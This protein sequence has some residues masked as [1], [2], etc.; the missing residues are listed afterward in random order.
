MNIQVLKIIVNEK[1]IRKAE[2]AR[3]SNVSR[4][5]VT[6]W[7]LESAETGWANV[8][9]NTLMKLGEAL[10]VDPSI[11]LTK[12]QALKPLEPRFLW[13]RLYPDMENFLKGIGRGDRV[14]LARLVQV[15][16]FHEGKE[17]AG[18]KAIAEFSA[19][20]KYLKPGRRKQL[21]ILWPLYNSQ[22]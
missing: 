15:L 21:E 20:K 2:L 11:F 19:Y 7:F 6:R 3:L 14:A 4:A 12:P 17:V 13:D 8:E 16:G 22:N 1:N 10:H 9:T 18:K 5:A